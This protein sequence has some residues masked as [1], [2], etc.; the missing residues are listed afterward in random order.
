MMIPVVACELID[1]AEGCDGRQ[2]SGGCRTVGEELGRGGRRGCAP[3]WQRVARSRGG[4]SCLAG[5]AQDPVTGAE[6]RA[7]GGEVGGGRGGAEVTGRWKA[8]HGPMKKEEGRRQFQ[9]R[10]R[11]AHVSFFKSKYSAKPRRRARH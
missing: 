4:G 11:E 2:S 5:A 9:E 3:E 1:M 10:R 8:V 7:G 6:G